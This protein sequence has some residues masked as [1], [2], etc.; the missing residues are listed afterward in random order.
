MAGASGASSLVEES[1]HDKKYDR[2]MRLWGSHG[3]KRL[4]TSHICVLHSGPT[5]AETLKNLVLPCIGAF[6]LVDDAIVTEEDCGNNFFVDTQHIGRSRAETVAELL[7]EL[8]P[9]V[10]G[11]ALVK[12]PR[13]LIEED[14]TFFSQ[15]QLVVVSQL[16]TS[17]CLLLSEYCYEKAIP[18]LIL[19]SYGLLASARVVIKE[20]TVIG[21]FLLFIHS[22]CNGV[23]CLHFL[24]VSSRFFFLKPTCVSR[25]LLCFLPIFLPSFLT[26]RVSSRQ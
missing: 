13:Q 3:Q 24:R 17:T 26:N 10:R 9:E 4:Q 2:Q 6:T 16:P 19:R 22:C 25:F 14:L 23:P 8:N 21:R 1:E 7:L 20:H 18:L 5:S 15:F 11:T 12:N